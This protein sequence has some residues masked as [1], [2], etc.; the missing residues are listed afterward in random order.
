MAHVHIRTNDRLKKK[1]QA[2][3]KKIGLDLSSAINMY[4]MQVV[5]RDGIP[6]VVSADGGNRVPGAA[7]GLIDAQGIID[8]SLPDEVLDAFD[9]PKIFPDEKKMKK[10]PVGL[11][12]GKVTIDMSHFDDPLPDEIQQAFDDPKIFP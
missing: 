8:E 5:I 12:K 10:R 4:L 3:L 9:D 2:I 11:A 1:A 7:R 6:F